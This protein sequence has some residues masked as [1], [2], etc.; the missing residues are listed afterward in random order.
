MYNLYIIC[1]CAYVR[2]QVCGDTCKL[3]KWC[4][5]IQC[6]SCER[7]VYTCHVTDAYV[8]CDWYRVG[9]LSIKPLGH[10]HY[11]S[12]SPHLLPTRLELVSQLPQGYP[13]SPSN[14]V[15]PLNGMEPRVA[16]WTLDHYQRPWREGNVNV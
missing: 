12:P 14:Y 11:C 3:C 15:A 8:S 9:W 16:S 6:M 5:Y 2:A 13:H 4:V 7:Y 10:V 1:V